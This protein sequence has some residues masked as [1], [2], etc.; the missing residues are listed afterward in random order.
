M[1]SQELERYWSELN[2]KLVSVISYP[3]CWLAPVPSAILVSQ[4]VGRVFKLW[5]PVAWVVAAVI[6][7]LGLVTTHE[8]L[9]AREGNRRAGRGFGGA[10]ELLAVALVLS[11]FAVTEAFIVTLG[12]W[13]GWLFPGLSAVAVL[14]LNL[15]MTRHVR[16]EERARRSAVRSAVRSVVVRSADPKLNALLNAVNAHPGASYA[17]LGAAVAQAVG[18]TKPYS[19]AWVAAKLGPTRGRGRRVGGGPGIEVGD[20]ADLGAGG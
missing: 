20:P 3:A 12:E 9:I 11:Y 19:K 13:R 7:L 2:A 10:G 18:R 17:E 8:W 16:A 14:S 5:P 15:R 4:A 6:E 1:G